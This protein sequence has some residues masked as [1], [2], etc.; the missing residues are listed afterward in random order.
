MNID[1]ATLKTFERVVRRLRY[2][3]TWY[4]SIPEQELRGFVGTWVLERIQ[5]FS[6]IIKELESGLHR[7]SDGGRGNYTP[8]WF[9]Q[10][11]VGNYQ[12]SE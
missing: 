3:L 6:M 10:R 4:R 8:S 1:D 7:R 2:Y 11:N 12:P 9:N 5:L